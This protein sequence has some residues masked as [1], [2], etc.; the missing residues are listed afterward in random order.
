MNQDHLLKTLL[1]LEESKDQ[2]RLY[3]KIQAVIQQLWV[4]ENYGPK[5]LFPQ[6]ELQKISRLRKSLDTQLRTLESEDSHAWIDTLLNVAYRL[7]QDKI[8]LLNDSILH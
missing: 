4:I 5:N 3:F 2:N 7:I 6:S 1:K 8:E